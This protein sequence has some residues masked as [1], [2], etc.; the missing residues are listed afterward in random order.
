MS[1]TVNGFFGEFRFLSNFTPALVRLG[2]CVYPSIE[3][4]YQAAKSTD[5]DLRLAFQNTA[6]TSGQAKR[7]GKTL[8]VRPD[9]E[10]IKLKVMLGLLRQKFAKPQYAQLLLATTGD[11]VETNTWGD[12]YWGVCNGLGSNHLGKLLM[13]V[14]DELRVRQSD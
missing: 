5:S 3:H 11:L 7:L 14:R 9:W 1:K 2:G 13:Q 12:R 4:A 8:I 6:L 10:D